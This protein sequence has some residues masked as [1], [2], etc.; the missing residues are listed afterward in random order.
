MRMYSKV[1]KPIMD[2]LLALLFVLLFFWVY[3]ILAI[4]VRTKLG[5]PIF[6]KQD[7]V[8]KIDPRTGK[9]RIFKLYKFRTMTDKRDES[10]NL[11]PDKLRLTSFG[12][13][14]RATS[15]DELPEIFFN[16]LFHYDMSL[17]GPRPLLVE[18]IARY[19][20]EQRRRSDCHP[21]LTG[22]AQVNG[23]NAVSWEDKFAMDVWYSKNISLALDI[24]II[25]D[26][27]KTV[28]RRDDIGS[29]NSVTMDVFRGSAPGTTS[30]WKAP[31]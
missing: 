10:G 19:S 3:A 24:K 7:R 20:P 15:L 28:V 11:L 30:D 16:I 5:S 2:R 12:K 26:T 18:Y 22:Y 13:K 29:A 14:L 1:V 23:R 9:E 31:Y 4:L 6:F 27:F 8:G 21:G 17:V 25:L